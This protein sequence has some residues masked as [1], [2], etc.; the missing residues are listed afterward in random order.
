MEKL[1]K[2]RIIKR[3]EVDSNNSL[4]RGTCKNNICAIRGNEPLCAW[5]PEVSS[6]IIH[7]CVVP[8][9]DPKMVPKQ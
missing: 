4:T 5:P 6:Y 7:I 3:T 2:I 9:S 1:K 8:G